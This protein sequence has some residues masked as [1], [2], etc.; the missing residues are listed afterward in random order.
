MFSWN[1]LTFSMIQWMLAIWSLVLL[2]FLN[3]TWTTES[4]WFMYLWSLAWRILRVCLLRCARWVQLWG[5]LSIFGIAF[6][7]DWNENWPFLVGLPLLSFPNLL[8]YW[9]QH[10]DSIIFLIW[11]SSTRIPSL[12]LALFLV[13]L[14]KAHLTLHSRMSGSRW[15]IP[16]WWLSRSGRSFCIVL[17]CILTTFS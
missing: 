6:L 11:H 14:L 16:P 7:W 5:S 1:S 12:P 15:V 8:A 3:P 13:M 10:F 9:M 4:S 2:L 17:L